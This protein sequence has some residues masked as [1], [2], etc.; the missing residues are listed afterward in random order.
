[1]KYLFLLVSFYSAVSSAKVTF[2]E[3]QDI[4][5]NIQNAGGYHVVLKL[6]PDTDIN[7]YTTKNYIA[8]NQGLLDMA[9]YNGVALV[10][11]HELGHWIEQ[12]PRTDEQSAKFEERADVIGDRLCRKSGFKHCLKFMQDMKRYDDGSGDGIHP[13]W[14]VRIENVLRN[15]RVE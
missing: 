1:M 13:S 14:D 5:S 3:A 6:D 7:A 15:R 9:D 2:K 8:V 11:G 4:F 10:L 12:D